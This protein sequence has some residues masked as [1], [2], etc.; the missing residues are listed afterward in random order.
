MFPPSPWLVAVYSCRVPVVLVGRLVGGQ[1][2]LSVG[3]VDL[4]LQGRSYG[5]LL[6]SPGVPEFGP[7]QGVGGDGTVSQGVLP[8]D[9]PASQCCWVLRD[10]MKCQIALGREVEGPQSMVSGR[11]IGSISLCFP[12]RGGPGCG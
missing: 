7:P 12:L 10:P 3:R 8:P 11:S 1:N 5:L 9:R 4:R 2:C 6:V